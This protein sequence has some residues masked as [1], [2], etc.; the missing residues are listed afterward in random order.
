MYLV[1]WNDNTS[2]MQGLVW[3]ER[4]LAHE[5]DFDVENTIALK[6]QPSES[7]TSNL[8]MKLTD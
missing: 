3:D 8:M 4:E 6:L 1:Q 5:Y 7:S 2:D